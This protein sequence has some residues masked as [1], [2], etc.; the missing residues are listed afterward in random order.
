MAKEMYDVLVGLRVGTQQAKNFAQHIDYALFKYGVRDMDE[1]AIF[2]ANAI[3]ESAHMTKLRENMNYSTPEALKSAFKSYFI[4]VDPKLYLHNSKKLGNYVY[5]GRNGNRKGTDDGYNYRGGGLFHTTGLGQYMAV[6]P[7]FNGKYDVVK[8]PDDM[9][10]PRVASLSAVWYF[11]FN[12]FDKTLKNPANGSKGP[13]YVCNRLNTGRYNWPANQLELRLTYYQKAL[14]LLQNYKNH[15]DQ[16]AE[17]KSV[18][19]GPATA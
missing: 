10:I 9:T 12:G 18:D 3:V 11:K 17:E 5:N 8:N 16:Y 7:I 2:L 19:G 13:E 14:I 15:Y 6:N 1:I 4:T